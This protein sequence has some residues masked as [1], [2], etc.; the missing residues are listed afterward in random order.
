[1]T[2]APIAFVCTANICRSPMAE[3]I[4]A[5]RH[6]SVPTFSCGVRSLIGAPPDELARS[7]CARHA[8]PIAESKISQPLS[9]GELARAQ[10]VLVMERA[11]RKSILGRIPE[12]AGKVW[13]AAEWTVGEVDDPVGQDLEAFDRCYRVLEAAIGTWAH[14]LGI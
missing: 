7:V 12:L 4:W 2:P 10:L 5:A 3:A 14:R 13:L 9:R 11:H 8:T 1:M 6:P